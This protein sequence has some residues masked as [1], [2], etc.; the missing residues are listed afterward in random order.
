MII[1]VTDLRPLGYCLSGARLFFKKHGLDFRDF[2]R[3][4]IDAQKL[5]RTTNNDDM[6]LKLIASAKSRGDHGGR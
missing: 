1:L 2:V 6:C 5:K 4:G 3:N